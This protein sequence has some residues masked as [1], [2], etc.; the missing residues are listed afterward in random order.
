MM[1]LQSNDPSNSCTILTSNQNDV[2]SPKHDVNLA[3]GQLYIAYI[4]I[5]TRNM[6]QC[7]AQ[8]IVYYIYYD[9]GM[10]YHQAEIHHINND[11][12]ESIESNA[13]VSSR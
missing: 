1:T 5:F 9:L 7:F 8:Y 11:I 6:S 12:D 10:Y 3:I 2:K 4:P 13:I